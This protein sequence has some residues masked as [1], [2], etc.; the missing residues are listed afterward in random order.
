LIKRDKKPAITQVIN[1]TRIAHFG[2][3]SHKL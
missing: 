1:H 2:E 3:D